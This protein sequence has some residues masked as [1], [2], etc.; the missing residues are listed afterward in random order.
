M[1]ES[2]AS[3]LAPALPPSAMGRRWVLERLGSFIGI[4]PL[5]VWTTVHLWNNLSAFAGPLAWSDAVTH[6]ENLAGGYAGFVA[7]LTFLIWHAVWGL[8]RL[9]TARPNASPYLGNWRYW[10]Q[11]LSGIGL[12]LFLGAHIFLAKL[13][14]LF[15]TGRPEPFADLAAHMAH[16]PPTLAVYLLGV[17]GIAYHLGNGVSNFLFSFGL[18]S[19][20]RGLRSATWVSALL[21][22]ALAA[23]GLAAIYAVF[24]AGQPYPTPID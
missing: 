8:Q 5:G 10:L 14:P 21:F 9:L 4:A 24:V 18:V 2:A 19:S 17:L 15:E 16:N 20:Q 11:R 7:V 23:V 22:G 6:H 12:L 3:S 1:A 13:Q